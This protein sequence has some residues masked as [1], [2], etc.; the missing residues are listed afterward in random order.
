[1]AYN[2]YNQRP[3]VR[4]PR[5]QDQETYPPTPYRQDGRDGRPQY[6]ETRNNQQGNRP[7]VSGHP[8]QASARYDHLGQYDQYNQRDRYN[9]Y[10]QFERYNQNNPR[11]QYSYTQ[12]PQGSHR[13]EDQYRDPQLQHKVDMRP[14]VQPQRSRG[15]EVQ[16]EEVGNLERRHNSAPQQEQVATK[17]KRR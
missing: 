13:S 3:Q 1:M 15:Q 2:Q 11:G 17:P 12:P 7:N 9:Q 16:W 10:E 6:D 4:Q 5:G 8:Q 14:K